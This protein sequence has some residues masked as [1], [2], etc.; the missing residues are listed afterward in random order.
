MGHGGLASQALSVLGDE[1]LDHVE[2]LDEAFLIDK[3][4]LLMCGIRIF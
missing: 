4:R 1:T 2:D 3:E